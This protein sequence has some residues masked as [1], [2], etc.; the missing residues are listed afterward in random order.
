MKKITTIAKRI[1][2]AP[3]YA[4]VAI[5]FGCNEIVAKSIARATDSEFAQEVGNL[6]EKFRNVSVDCMS[7][8]V[9]I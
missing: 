3:A 5:S 8:K 1:I 4:C 6:C 9:S 2:M 7:G